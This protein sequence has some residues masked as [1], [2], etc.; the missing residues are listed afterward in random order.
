MWSPAHPAR[1]IPHGFVS[2][3]QDD[4]VSAYGAALVVW[5]LTSVPIALL[6]GLTLRRSRS[7]S[8]IVDLAAA[9][10]VAQAERIVARAATTNSI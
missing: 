10:A 8:T 5:I 6:V 3:A 1:T 9:E 2:G 7:S 4:R